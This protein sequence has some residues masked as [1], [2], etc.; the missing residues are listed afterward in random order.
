MSRFGSPLAALIAATLVF[1]CSSDDS[2]DDGG[3]GTGGS[4]GQLPPEI[5][6]TADI[7]PILQQKCG[8]SDCHDGEQ[9]PILP[10]HGAADVAEAYAATQ[11]TSFTGDPVYERILARITDE[12]SMMPP[13][14]ASPPC[15]GEIGSPGCVTQA[16]LDLIEAWIEA[17][18]PL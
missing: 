10:G 1:G 18:T 5:T 15:Q 2:G 4:G 3:G 16:E 6:F 13:N 12:T 11:A 7:H 17:G 8:A 14:F 9:A